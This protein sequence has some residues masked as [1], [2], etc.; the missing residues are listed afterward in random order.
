MKSGIKTSEFWITIANTV[1]MVA[2]A[3][4]LSQEEADSLAAVI[5]PLV[6]A[7]LPIVAYILS[8]AHIKKE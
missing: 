3:F 8:R 1:L 6:A 7:V 2:V 5:A 4:G